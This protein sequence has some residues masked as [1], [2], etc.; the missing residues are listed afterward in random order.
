MAS[1]YAPKKSMRPRSRNDA[2]GMSPKELEDSTSSP[3]R[4]NMEDRAELEKMNKIHRASSRA[5]SERALM[6]ADPRLPGAAKRK[7]ED[8]KA[9]QDL[10]GMLDG[11]AKKAYGGK[12]KKVYKMKDGGSCRGMG[13]ATRGGNFVKG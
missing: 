5:G 6:A 1:K 8:K 11:P 9:L 2:K 10:L 4:L 13:A 12:M 3:D 7:A